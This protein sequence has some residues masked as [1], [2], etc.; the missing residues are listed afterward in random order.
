VKIRFGGDFYLKF[1]GIKMSVLKKISEFFNDPFFWNL[2][3]AERS[4]DSKAMTM[5]FEGLEK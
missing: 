1:G 3:E 2:Y 4:P 5:L